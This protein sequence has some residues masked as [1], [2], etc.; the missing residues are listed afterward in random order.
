[1]QQ[2]EIEYALLN[3]REDVDNSGQ[4]VDQA[5]KDLL[6]SLMSGGSVCPCCGA[7]VKP[8]KIGITQKMVAEM[9]WLVDA[10][11]AVEGRAIYPQQARFVDFSDAPDEIRASRTISKLRFFGLVEKKAWFDETGE[12]HEVQGSWRPTAK[13]IKFSMDMI[14]IQTRAI[15]FRNEAVTMIGERETA[16]DIMARGRTENEVHHDS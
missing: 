13:G 15:V 5:R 9:R 10:S 8:Y 11:G 3:S 6:G 4:T 1:M 2:E 7:T 12:E 14:N 16:S